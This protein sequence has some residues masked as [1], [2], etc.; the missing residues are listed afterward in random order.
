MDAHAS[1]SPCASPVA[2]PIAHLSVGQALLRSRATL[3]RAA[4]LPSGV[5]LAHWRN[6]DTATEYLQPEHHTLSFYLEGGHAV[7][8]AEAP[9]ARG[10]PGVL[11]CLPA[12]HDSR[13]AVNGELQLMHLYLPQLQ[14]AQAAEAWFERDPRSVTLAERI[15]FRDP[16]LEALCSAMAAADWQAPDAALRLQQITLDVQTCLLG[17]HTV[18]RH[19]LPAVRGGLAPAAR[20]RVLE[21]IESGLL[22][23]SPPES[24]NLT[25]LAAAACLSEYHFA[26]MFKASFGCSPHAW[27]M[28]R[29]L[30]LARAMLGDGRLAFDEVARRC[31]YAHLSHLNAALR[32]AGLASASRYR[33]D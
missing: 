18:R 16:R 15:Y 27:V 30:E 7:R 6:A 4:A 9:A 3:Q 1:S 8:C 29:R 22:G 5:W 32:R 28:R 19:P 24:L 11:C 10:E 17:E 21:R 14:L 2:A 23:Q 12:G 31:G 25:A 20:R 13:W 26:R 33:R